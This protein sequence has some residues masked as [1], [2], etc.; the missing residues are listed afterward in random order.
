MIRRDGE[1]DNV[2]LVRGALLA[3]LEKQDSSKITQY[4]SDDAVLQI[5]EKKLVGMKQIKAR[6]DWIKENT[7]NVKVTIKKIIVSGDEGFDLHFSEAID[8]QGEKHCVKVMGYFRIRE[9]KIFHYEDVT[10]QLNDG[11]D[12]SLATSVTAPAV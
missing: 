8:A 10:I 3:V 12:L 11:Q 2:T 1:N 4:F 6:I 5:N 7:T 9:G